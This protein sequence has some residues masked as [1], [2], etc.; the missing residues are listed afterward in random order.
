[1]LFRSRVGDEMIDILGGRL[2]EFIQAGYREDNVLITLQ[3]RYFPLYD[4]GQSNLLVKD[5]NGKK[6]VDTRSLNARSMTDNY[7]LRLNPLVNMF[8]E[9]ENQEAI[10][11]MQSAVNDVHW[12][13]D[14][15]GGNLKGVIN[16][17]YGKVWGKYFEDYVNMMANGNGNEI[18]DFDKTINR[19]IGNIAVSR[20]G[21][22]L[23]T[24][25][26]QLVSL[27]PAMT[28]GELTIP[29][30]LSALRM[31]TGNNTS[32][33][34]NDFILENASSVFYSA[35]NVEAQSALKRDEAVGAGVLKDIRE[36]SMW[37]T[38]KL[39]GL[40]KKT[41]WLAEYQKQI[42][43]GTRHIDAVS[44]ATQLVENTQSVTDNPS[45]AKLQ[46]NKNPLVRLSFMFTND[47]FQTWNMITYDIPN[48]IRNG[49]TKRALMESFGILLQ[50][51]VIAFLAGGWLGDEKDDDPWWSDFL[52]DFAVEGSSYLPIAGPFLQDLVRGYS[53]S[54]WQG[55]QEGVD[56]LKM[57]VN[58]CQYWATDGKMGKDYETPDWVNQAV[59]V[60]EELLISPTGADR[61]SVV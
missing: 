47:L 52:G 15:N 50:G 14:R 29:E 36:T 13:L 51:G 22:N 8:A 40:V 60:T 46:M 43:K 2:N 42:K 4:S 41:V 48:A 28:R 12:I 16:M 49:N 23:M 27:I 1:M 59:D 26:K 39:D 32:A 53:S 45:L 56:T 18:E 10:I 6:R 30:V 24:S 61:K 20:I 19:F 37:L 7:P 3:D 35:Y 21:L 31:V 9:I 57:I 54:F 44:I 5:K 25:I 33:S 55:P 58:Q 11:N 34:V 38:K 17:K